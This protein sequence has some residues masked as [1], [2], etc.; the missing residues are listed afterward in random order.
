MVIKT[1]IKILL[2]IICAPQKKGG[3]SNTNKARKLKIE[4]N[5]GHSLVIFNKLWSQ[6]TIIFDFYLNKLLIKS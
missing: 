2:N 5:C 1:F 4:I 3:L 6:S